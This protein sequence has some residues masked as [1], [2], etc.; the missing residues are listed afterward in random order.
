MWADK[1]AY[2]EKNRIIEAHENVCAVRESDSLVCDDVVITKY[3]TGTVAGGRGP[4]SRSMY[5]LCARS[6]AMSAVEVE[7]VRTS[8]GVRRLVRGGHRPV[9][10]RTSALLSSCT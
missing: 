4:E 5:S 8:Q 2:D 6:F 9:H 1:V 7:C 3:F 10:R